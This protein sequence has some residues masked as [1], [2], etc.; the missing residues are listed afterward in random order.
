[1]LPLFPIPD[2]F[3]EGFHVGIFFEVTKQLKQEKTNRIIGE[4]KNLISMGNDRSNKGE[5]YQGRDESRKPAY[6]TSIGIDFNISS[7]V[8]V[9]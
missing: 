6:N 8:G 9:F 1:V 5:V 3:N 4:S 7:L 2:D